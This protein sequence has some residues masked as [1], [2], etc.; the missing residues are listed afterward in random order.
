ACE[1]MPLS[2]SRVLSKKP[3]LTSTASRSGPSTSRYEAATMC[4]EGEQ[5]EMSDVLLGT[6]PQTARPA[7]SPVELSDDFDSSSQYGLDLLFE[8]PAEE[9]GVSEHRR[10]GV[11]SELSTPAAESQL[12]ADAEMAAALQRTARKTG[13]EWVPLPGGAARD[14]HP[15]STSPAPPRQQPPPAPHRGRP[16]GRAAQAPPQAGPA[17]RPAQRSSSHRKVAPPALPQAT[18]NPHWQPGEGGS[19]DLGRALDSTPI[20]ATLFSTAGRCFLQPEHAV[21]HLLCSPMF[22]NNEGILCLVPTTRT[23]RAKQPVVFRA[24]YLQPQARYVGPFGLGYAIHFARRP[25]KFHGILSTSVWDENTAVFHAEIAVLLVNDAIETV[26]DSLM[27]FHQT[28]SLGGPVLAQQNLVLGPGAPSI[29]SSL[30]QPSEEGPPFSGEG[31][32]LA[33]TS[34]PL[35]PPPLVPRRDQEDFRD[36][37]SSV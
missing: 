8:A 1:D 34:R 22:W 9:Q 13:L 36:L 3:W 7:C 24:S 32:N 17:A 27:L 29:S 25:P 23:R 35:E 14:S 2:S 11:S 33:P 15:A 6:S 30:V 12:V 10:E 21:T 18:K 4:T 28:D 5:G 37:S 26:P 16:P 19:F 31:H 20:S